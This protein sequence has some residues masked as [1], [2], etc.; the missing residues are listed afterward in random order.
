MRSEEIVRIVFFT[1]EK[2]NE[3]MDDICSN[4]LMQTEM[5]SIIYRWKLDKN[6]PTPKGKQRELSLREKEKQ[7]EQDLFECIVPGGG[8][9]TVLE[10]V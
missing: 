3:K 7:L 5:L 10:L 2:A 9:T 6:D 4:T 1:M 8:K